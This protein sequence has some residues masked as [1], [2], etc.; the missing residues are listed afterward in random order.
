MVTVTPLE[1]VTSPGTTW[2]PV[3][4]AADAVASFVAEAPTLKT[5]SEDLGLIINT[6]SAI[7]PVAVNKLDSE[8]WSLI[9]PT[10]ASSMSLIAASASVT[11]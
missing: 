10:S 5:V 8:P 6:P 1:L 4:E 7:I 9:I 11:V 2:R 3:V